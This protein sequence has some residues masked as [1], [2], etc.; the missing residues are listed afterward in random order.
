MV[1]TLCVKA[2]VLYS[3]HVSWELG[4]SLFFRTASFSAWKG[5][6]KKK[7][8]EFFKNNKWKMI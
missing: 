8:L 3:S 4:F 7:V 5:Q 6:K 1:L 2:I